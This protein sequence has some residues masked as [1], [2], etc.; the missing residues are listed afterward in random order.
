MRL[1]SDSDEKSIRTGTRECVYKCETLRLDIRSRRLWRENSPLALAPKSFELLRILMENSDRAMSKHELLEALW[2]DVEVEEGNLPFQIS[3]LR[4][5]LG[6]GAGKWIETV[7]RHGYRWSAPVSRHVAPDTETQTA[8][9]VS[10]ASADAGAVT[11]T[12]ANQQD[13]EISRRVTVLDEISTS[14]SVRALVFSDPG[15]NHIELDADLRALPP[16]TPRTSLIG[17]EKEVAAVKRLLLSPDVR[18]L[19]LT[20]AGG[21]GKTRLALQV[22]TN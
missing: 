3:A 18:L 2:P 6:P 12:L 9:R 21:V 16:P 1:A 5:A 8:N 7:P 11:G 17:R 14:Q 20:G 19:T 13:V 22:T 4:K 10:K 15:G